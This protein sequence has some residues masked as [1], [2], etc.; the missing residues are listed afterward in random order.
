[1]R[2][3]AACPEDMQSAAN[4]LA[5]ALAFSEADAL[6]YIAPSWQ[7][8]QGRLYAAASW[9]IVPEWL[10]LAQ[11]PLVRPAW[12]ADQII[13]IDAAVTAQA[14]L[15]PVPIDPLGEETSA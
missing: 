15:E 6:T 5:M 4:H 12:D 9:L 2:V 7:D 14:A 1:M 11:S 13:D 8:A 10:D 3:T